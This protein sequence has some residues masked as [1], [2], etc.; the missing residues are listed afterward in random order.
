[1]AP[2]TIETG[3]ERINRV[4]RE[5]ERTAAEAEARRRQQSREAFPDACLRDFGLPW[6]RG[7]GKPLTMAEKRCIFDRKGCPRRKR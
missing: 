7:V 5:R 2:M 6:K 4:R 3:E 1:M